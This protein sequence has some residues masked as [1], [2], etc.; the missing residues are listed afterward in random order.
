[1]RSIN[2]QLARQAAFIINNKGLNRYK[3]MAKSLDDKLFLDGDTKELDAY[4][5]RN[6]GEHYTA[7]STTIID[8]IVNWLS[9]IIQLRNQ[10]F[11]LSK[12]DLKNSDVQAINNTL[13]TGNL[14]QD[15]LFT[16]IDQFDIL[17]EVRFALKKAIRDLFKS[18][19]I[20]QYSFAF[21]ERKHPYWITD[22][23]KRS[24]V[25]AKKLIHA[26][27]LNEALS[28]FRARDFI[29]NVLELVNH[30]LEKE[31]VRSSFVTWVYQYFS[32]RIEHE[33]D[34]K[35]HVFLEKDFPLI[36]EVAMCVMYY[37]NQIL[38]Q[39]GGV[40]DLYH[41]KVNLV[42][43]TIMKDWCFEYLEETLENEEHLTIATD[44]LRKIFVSVDIGQYLDKNFNTFEKFDDNSFTY[45]GLSEEFLRP[46][47]ENEHGERQEIGRHLVRDCIDQIDHRTYQNNF[48]EVK[49]L[50]GLKKDHLQ[51]YLDRIS[52]TSTMLFQLSVANI[53][54]LCVVKREDKEKMLGMTQGYGLSLQIINDYA[55]FVHIPKYSSILGSATI[56]KKSTDIFKDVENRT[57]SLPMLINLGKKNRNGFL[58]KFLK[59]GKSRLSQTERYLVLKELHQTKSLVLCESITQDIARQ[60]KI[61]YKITRTNR[62]SLF[63]RDLWSICFVNRFKKELEFKEEGFQM[64][65]K[66]CDILKYQ[67]KYLPLELRAF[68]FSQFAMACWRRIKF[69]TLDI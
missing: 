8:K 49:D 38:D 56:E 9:D 55:D 30:K 65:K 53:A 46:L 12:K 14:E 2:K 63:L 36:I 28:A 1:M 35:L 58:Y 15:F 32:S 13:I 68:Q 59:L 60:C 54:D 42:A 64:L 34:E 7:V 52:L 19:S 23:R 10:I 69:T 45:A 41:F 39:K 16:Y 5:M 40:E 17:S 44:Y 22:F 66:F 21:A 26:R 11:F 25:E 29:D 18:I 43:R 57:M 6:I 62:A 3:A 24:A 47:W 50:L 27:I 33:I 67:G 4:L 61:R 37:D 51:L 48:R 31:S 20:L